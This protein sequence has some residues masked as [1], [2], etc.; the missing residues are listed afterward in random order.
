MR[1]AFGRLGK[2][3][4]VLAWTVNNAVM[5]TISVS[6]ERINRA[7]QMLDICCLCS[8]CQ[9][10]LISVREVAAMVSQLS[11]QYVCHGKGGLTAVDKL[12]AKTML[13]NVRNNLSFTLSTMSCKT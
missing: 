5:A 6:L 13:H 12:K 11:M 3:Q 2:L 4:D 7:L 10:A 9:G 1:I 8:V